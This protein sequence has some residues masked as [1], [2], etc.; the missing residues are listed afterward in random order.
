LLLK[1]PKKRITLLLTFFHKQKNPYFL[2]W[3]KEKIKKGTSLEK[4]NRNLVGG[5]AEHPN[6]F[7]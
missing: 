5:N 2:A 6:K 7:L 1:N 3:K 4:E